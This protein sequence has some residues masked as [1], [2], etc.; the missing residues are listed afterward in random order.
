MKKL[1]VAV[2]AACVL[3]TLSTAPRSYAANVNDF[4]IQDYQIDY[5]LKKDSTNRASLQTVE[6]ITAVFPDIDQNHGIERAIPITYDGHPTKVYL[7]A[8]SDGTGTAL[9]YETRGENGNTVI[10]IGDADT[11]VHGQQTYKLTYTQQDVTKYYRDTNDDE[12]Y[13]DTN[14]TGW[15][16]PI[17]HLSAQLHIVG[18]DLPKTLSGKQS[19]YQGSAGSTTPCD[20]TKTDD[21]FSAEVTNL[22]PYQNMTL[23]IGFKPHTF[24]VYQQSLGERIAAIWGVVQVVATVTG[25]VLTLYLIW[26]Y[27]KRSNRTA[28]I[29]TI[30]PEYVPP[31]DTSVA[32]AS[33]VSRKYNRTFAAQLLDF[34]VRHYIKIYQTSEKH[35]YRPAN[36]ELEIVQPIDTLKPEEQ[37]VLRDIFDDPVVGARLDMSTLRNNRTVAM[38][39]Q[40]NTTK[41]SALVT[42]RYGLRAKDE[43]QT[44]WF[45]RKGKWALVFAVL[46]LSPA[47]FVA[48]IVA[49]ICGWIIKPLTDKGLALARYLKG[50][51]LYITVAEEDRLRMLQSPE[52]A[53][54]LPAPIDT[55]DTRQLIKL[56][57]RLL[58][59]AVL[60]GK[61][62]QWN[63]Q[64]GSYYEAANE[65]PS[66]VGGNTA[67][68]NAVVL[69]SFVSNLNTVATYSDPSSSSSG[70]S[71]GGGSSGGGGGGGGGGGW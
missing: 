46:T 3:V 68:F 1:L 65:S 56:Y 36:Y 29:G 18:T 17:E 30:I 71:G 33:L 45:M 58:P 51:E 22:S 19:C 25:I 23:A 41:L 28:E 54:K 37:E 12:F 40:D 13:W 67:V 6:T 59:Y 43:T 21:G 9:H 32:V 48:A 4:V 57:E 5:Y 50:L 63:K 49:F 15:A 39:L 35:W 69:S 60:M 53:E 24:A 7:D 20:I 16:V 26:Q 34:A 31:A 42:D 44:K 64:L 70:G 10:R 62:K 47:L 55:N 27:A 38:S 11:Y 66:W 14:G 61:E 52:G 2:L 8:I